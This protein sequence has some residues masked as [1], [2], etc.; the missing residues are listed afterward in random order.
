MDS[1]I[2][3]YL[4]EIKI[5]IEQLEEHLKTAQAGNINLDA[6]GYK[7]GFDDGYEQGC[8]DS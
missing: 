1:Q 8:R 4:N 7:E 3:E 2:A 5:Y 6:K